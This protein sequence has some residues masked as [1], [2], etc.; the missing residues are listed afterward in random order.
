MLSLFDDKITDR[1]FQFLIEVSLG[2]HGHISKR[3][4][5]MCGA[6]FFF[7]QGENVHP[8]WIV[9]KVPMVPAD[10]RTERNRRFVREIELQHGTFYH[11]FV[12]WP[13]DYQ[14]VFDTP[15]ALYRAYDGDLSQWIPRTEWS[16]TSRLATLV[17]ICSALNHCRRRGIK[18]HQDLKPQNIL[19]RSDFSDIGTSSGSDV[20]EFPLLADFGL[21]NLSAEGG[22]SEGARPY[23]APEQWIDDVA[24]GESDIFSL[25]VIIFEVMTRGMHPYG[26]MTQEWWP[27]P[28]E[29][30]SKKWLRPDTWNKWALAGNPVTSEPFLAPGAEAIARQC[31]AAR[32]ADRP[33]LSEVQTRLLAV[34]CEH[35][36]AAE[37]QAQLQVS[38]AD[39][40]PESNEWP[41]RDMQLERLRQSVQEIEAAG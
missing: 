4:S 7:D 2:K 39:N 8:R 24:S 19:M 14:M 36:Q 3:S 16:I 15:V 29:G 41:Y 30:K 9:A 11:R 27:K 31:M 22:S 33:T 10:D 25:G 20:F 12:C 5:G 17:Y 37:A 38:H 23:M 18:C 32:P 21:A 40:Y 26:G 6:V 35:D 13:F 28:T 1:D 34:L